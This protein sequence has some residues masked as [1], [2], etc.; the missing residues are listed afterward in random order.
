MFSKEQ[1]IY[2]DSPGSEGWISINKCRWTAPDCLRD[3]I[4]L[5]PIFPALQ[6]LF[7]NKL[8][9]KNATGL[10]VAHELGRL[11]GRVDQFQQIKVLLLWLGSC[12]ATPLWNPNIPKILGD[13]TILPV[14]M[15]ET[16]LRA[17]DDK[18]WFIS[19]EE[20]KLERFFTGKV[21]LLDLSQDDISK[22]WPL[23][24]K[25]VVHRRTLKDNFRERNDVFRVTNFHETLT[26]G[27]RK[28][29][30]YIAR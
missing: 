22:L 30:I 28:K 6:D 7:L 14:K 21:W 3:I 19:K 12:I 27:L 5:Q 20:G 24:E 25:L 4:S 26:E 29:A 16:S 1:V 18:D 17:P 15:V 11:S 8:G 2:V 13:K 10:D 23:L 9:V